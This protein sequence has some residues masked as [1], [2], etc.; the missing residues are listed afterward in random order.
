MLV[1]Q[2]QC[3]TTLY[4]L[5]DGNGSVVASTDANGTVVGSRMFR[6]DGVTISSTGTNTTTG[7]GGMDT[8]KVPGLLSLLGV[9]YDPQ[10]ASPISLQCEMFTESA[11]GDCVG[12]A[13]QFATGAQQPPGG[14]SDI[15]TFVYNGKTQ[16]FAKATPLSIAFGMAVRSF[17]RAH[18]SK[19][20]LSE[21]FSDYGTVRLGNNVALGRVPIVDPGLVELFAA[22]TN[23]DAPWFKV[24]QDFE[25][26]TTAEYWSLHYD[27]D[28]AWIYDAELWPIMPV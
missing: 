25:D 7:F 21:N 14:S 10:T 15:V 12:E 13:L 19:Y 27:S 5:H 9:L 20:P 8:T 24:I 26:M 3:G 4:P 18:P 1:S 16:L 22:F 2:S 6:P 17:R 28:G 23:S 11:E